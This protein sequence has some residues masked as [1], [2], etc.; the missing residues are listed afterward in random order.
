MSIV[1]K[2][3]T[4]FS[5]KNKTEALF[6]RTKVSAISDDNGVG[7]NVI[8]DDINT[9]VANVKTYTDNALSQ[10]SQVQII[11]WEADD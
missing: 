6:P 1:G 3:K 7:L 2:I 11:T 5:D 8:L 9:K 10:K 4:L